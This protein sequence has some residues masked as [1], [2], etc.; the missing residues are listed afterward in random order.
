MKYCLHCI[1]VMTARKHFLKRFYLCIWE[2]DRTSTGRGGGQAGL[3]AEHR[4]WCS[5]RAHHPEIVTCAEIE[6]DA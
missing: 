5:V 3:R 6:S 1:W 2:R 4:A